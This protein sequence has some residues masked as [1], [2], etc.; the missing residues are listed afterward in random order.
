VDRV[1]VLAELNTLAYY[2]KEVNYAPK[3][4]KAQVKG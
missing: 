1:E 2:S 3:I 4:M